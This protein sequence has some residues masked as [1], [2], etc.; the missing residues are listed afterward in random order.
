MVV[1]DG[2][3]VCVQLVAS[4]GPV[5]G[6]S[7][8]CL[9]HHI[10]DSVLPCFRPSPPSSAWQSIHQSIAA[11][12]IKKTR[13]VAEPAG[14]GS[15]CGSSRSIVT[16]NACPTHTVSRKGPFRTFSLVPPETPSGFACLLG[17]L[18]CSLR[19]LY[20]TSSDTQYPFS[21]SVSLRLLRYRHQ[22]DRRPSDRSASRCGS[23]SLG[24]WSCGW[25]E[26]ERERQRRKKAGL[27]VHKKARHR[28]KTEARIKLSHRHVSA[29]PP[30]RFALPRPPFRGPCVRGWAGTGGMD[31]DLDPPHHQGTRGTPTSCCARDMPGP[32][33]LPR[34]QQAYRASS[35]MPCHALPCHATPGHSPSRTTS[36]LIKTYRASHSREG[37]FSIP[38]YPFMSLHSL[39]I[40]HYCERRKEANLD[41]ITATDLATRQ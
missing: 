1:R 11:S 29:P 23:P 2:C 41:I 4:H 10:V 34:V 31:R 26:R 39:P 27:L 25:Q 19:H 20:G 13:D 38:F 15:T 8:F 7:V 40:L 3:F 36:R 33:A 18:L 22:N 28:R 37:L 30:N 21:C 5:A 35:A 6:F 17:A 32:G 24:V 12:F 16:A 9:A 14:V